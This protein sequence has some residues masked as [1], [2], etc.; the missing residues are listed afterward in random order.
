MSGFPPKK[1]FYSYN[2]WYYSWSFKLLDN[3]KMGLGVNILY[4]NPLHPIKK[5]PDSDML[6]LILKEI[7]FR[8]PI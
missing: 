8:K 6:F 4:H 3:L 2:F 7:P 5:I 1:N